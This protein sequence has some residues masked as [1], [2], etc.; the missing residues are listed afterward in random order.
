WADLNDP[1]RK[2][3][4]FLFEHHP[5]RNVWSFGRTLVAGLRP[6][7]FWRSL[8]P[9]QRPSPRR[10]L[11]YASAS[12]ILTFLI[13]PASV[14]AFTASQLLRYGI[15]ASWGRALAGAWYVRHTSWLIPATFYY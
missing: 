4:P 1:S 12:I 7:R 2:R 8:S 10:L 6:A 15:A 5:D 14:Y 9:A 13:G 3:H 11:V